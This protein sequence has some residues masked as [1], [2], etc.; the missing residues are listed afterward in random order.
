M[1]TN[2]NSNT[3]GQHA[4]V[5][6]QYTVPPS[7]TS[8]FAP[9][10]FLHIYINLHVPLMMRKMAMR[11]RTMRNMR[12]R[13]MRMSDI[14]PSGTSGFA[15]VFSAHLHLFTFSQRISLLDDEKNGGEGVPNFKDAL[16]AS[17]LH[18]Y[19]YLHSYILCSITRKIRMRNKT[20]RIMR[21]R[22]FQ[23]SGTSGFACVFFAHLHLFTCSAR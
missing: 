6:L 15:C 14:L 9:A 17:F 5:G 22:E 4:A 19:I 18:I 16:L 11:N 8:G 1:N 10:S 2:T 21:M 3:G 23:P 7:G 20:M 13:K 12:M